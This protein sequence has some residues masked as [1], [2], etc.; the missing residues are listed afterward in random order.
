MHPILYFCVI[1]DE[2]VNNRTD[3]EYSPQKCVSHSHNRQYGRKM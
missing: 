3:T 1:N 2:Y